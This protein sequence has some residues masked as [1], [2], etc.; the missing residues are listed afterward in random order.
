M[1][2]QYI[3]N[4]NRELIAKEVSKYI[5]GDNFFSENTKTKEFEQALAQYLNVKHVVTV[6]SGT[7]ALVLALLAEGVKPGDKVLIPNIT[8][9][10]T[11]SAV[12]LIGA[13][14]VFIDIDPDN[15]C[16]KLNDALSQISSEIKAIIMVHL[17]GRSHGMM[18]YSNFL[19]LCKKNE[20]K[21]IEDNAQA[22]GSRNDFNDLISHPSSGIGCFSLS[23]HKLLSSGQG[24]FCV[25]N[26]DELNIKLRELKNVGRV[27]GGADIHERFGINCKF[28]DI[29]AIIGMVGL[30][31]IEPTI[32]LKKWTY[33][34]YQIRLKNVSQ[35]RFIKSD[36]ETFTPWFMD[37]YVERREELQSY[38]KERGIGTRAIYPELT[39]QKL[40]RQYDTPVNL[41]VSSKFTKEGLW[42]PSS[43]SITSDEISFV[44]ETIK[45]FYVS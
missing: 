32:A 39:S 29:Q 8:M 16:M 24:G 20:I 30:E 9:M 45:E 6:T 42:L 36:L 7:M 11:Q 17:N 26:N 38:L 13:I 14:P 22:F 41:P 37:V 23:F 27:E 18:E 15:L 2:P 3:P 43:L 33:L 44:C 28:T 12:E 40:N 21:V 31:Q 25:T 35:V 10:S 1:I 4:Y 34:E 19:R 5:L